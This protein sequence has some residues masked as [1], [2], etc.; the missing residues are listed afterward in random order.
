MTWS[1]DAS[2][3]SDKDKV[4]LYIGDTDTNSQLVTDEAIEQMLADFGSVHL[5]A[6]ALADGLAA[7][8]SRTSNITIDGASF[9]GG[10]RAAE[11]RALALR[12]RQTAGTLPGGLGTPYV[13]GVS[14]SEMDS[15]EADEDRPE[16]FR[17]GQF[18]NPND[19]DEASA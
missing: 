8:F 5:A 17:E 11:Y 4:R 18:A 12:L 6:A 16:A 14:R 9:S 7:R 1:Y 10:S 3:A 15:V 2:L 19:G 13:G